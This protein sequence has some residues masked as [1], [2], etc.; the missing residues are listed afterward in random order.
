MDQAKPVD[1][2]KRIRT[3]NQETSEQA[4]RW[5]QSKRKIPFAIVLLKMPALFLKAY[6]IQGAWRRGYGGFMEAVH[7]ALYQLISYAK[8]WELKERERGLM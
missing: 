1:W 3:L 8:Y 6:F 2:S 4:D 5:F 7:Q